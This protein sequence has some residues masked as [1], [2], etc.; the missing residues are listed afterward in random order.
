MVGLLN[1]VISHH[2]SVFLGGAI[3][4][5]GIIC[6][7]AVVLNPH[8]EAQRKQQEAAR[9]KQEA[10]RLEAARK[11]QEAE[12]L[13]AARQK[14]EAERLEAARKQQEAERLEAARQK[15][16]A[17][18]LEAERQKQEAER[19]EAA[20]KQQEAERLEAER[21]KQEAER[22][23]AA[24]KK[25]EAERLEAE[26]KRQAVGLKPKT[27][28][29]S[30]EV[31]KSCEDYW[32]FA[33]SECRKLKTHK[34]DN[35]SD[36]AARKEIAMGILK[37]TNSEFTKTELYE[38]FKLMYRT[39]VHPLQKENGKLSSSL[40]QKDRDDVLR[41]AYEELYFSQFVDNL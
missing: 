40:E 14:Q 3:C 36:I 13:E 15:Q 20:R 38:H 9:K 33:L 23:E 22:L 12:R 1:F 28:P 39:Y 35:A 41:T 11:Q 25:Q 32:K 34:G 21:R 29:I 19:L 27:E 10:E 31:K 16:K 6:L 8:I 2:C 24:R 18:R 30:Q 7:L 5:I 4:V 37:L 26:R 17:E